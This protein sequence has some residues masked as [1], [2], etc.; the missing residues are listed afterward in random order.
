MG[1]ESECAWDEKSDDCSFGRGR[2]RSERPRQDPILSALLNP[3]TF[4]SRREETVGVWRDAGKIY[5][6]SLYP[7]APR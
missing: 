4:R 5:T 1:A 2:L 7:I 6:R 3:L